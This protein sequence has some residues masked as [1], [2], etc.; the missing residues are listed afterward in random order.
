M[1]LGALLTCEIYQM[2]IL[3]SSDQSS[4]EIDS[5]NIGPEDI[6]KEVVWNQYVLVLNTRV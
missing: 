5:G 1:L 4:N 3:S 6:S 2:E